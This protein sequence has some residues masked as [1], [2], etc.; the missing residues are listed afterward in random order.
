M[1]VSRGATWAARGYH[2][3]ERR[4]RAGWLGARPLVSPGRSP[5]TSRLGRGAPGTTLRRE[6]NKPAARQCQTR[7]Q[8][9]PK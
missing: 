4:T 1:L 3:R 2:I 7:G 9:L 5:L 8:R 6:E